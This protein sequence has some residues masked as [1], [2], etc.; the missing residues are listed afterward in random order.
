[1]FNEI[2]FKGKLKEIQ[3]QIKKKW[4]ELTDDE[5]LRTKGN[6]QSLFGVLEQKFG[7]KKQEF[8]THFAALK[9]EWFG[10]AD[11]EKRNASDA[12]NSKIDTAKDSLKK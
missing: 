8:E 9:N 4:G 3:G 7:A 2:E 1:M 10:K 5:L 11:A 6:W 12:V